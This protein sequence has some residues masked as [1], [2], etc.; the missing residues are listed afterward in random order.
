MVV[1]GGLVL[2]FPGSA[3]PG[4]VRSLPAGTLELRTRIRSPRWARA[5][6]IFVFVNGQLALEQAVDVTDEQVTDFDDTL[7]VPVDRDAWVV[8]LA[9]GPALRFIAPGAP[10]FAFSN[11]IGVD[12]DG[13]GVSGVG[14]GPVNRPALAIC[15]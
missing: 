4:E 15:D 3:G 10:A 7:R 8:V 11:P 13:G 9:T 2:D 6:R 1:S 5:E 12:V 14:P